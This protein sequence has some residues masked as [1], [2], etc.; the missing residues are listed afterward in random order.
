MGVEGLV[1]QNVASGDRGRVSKQQWAYRVLRERILDGRYGPGHR[2][3]IDALARELE[4]SQMPVREAIR[5]LEA[6]GWVVYQANYGAQVAPVDE[7][8]WAE[9]MTTL[10][11]LEGFATAQAAPRLTTADITDLRAINRRL[12]AAL[13]EL[14]LPA[15]AKHNHGFHRTMYEHCGNDYLRRQVEAAAERLDSLRRTTIFMFIPLR[16]RASADEHD[17]LIELIA[18]GSRPSAI[19]RYARQHKLATIKAYEQRR[20]QAVARRR[21]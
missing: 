5:R 4:V 10:A 14:D 18:S 19:E 11:L 8:A 3:V 15:I 9:A 16:G 17:H 2:L 21:R 1:R 7:S 6:E 13:D 20:R 12:R